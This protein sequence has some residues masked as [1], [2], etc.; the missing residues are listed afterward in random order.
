M[1]VADSRRSVQIAQLPPVEL[2]EIVAAPLEMVRRMSSAI[3]EAT[4]N[5][6]ENMAA[7]SERVASF[8]ELVSPREPEPVIT[9]ALLVYKGWGS[10]V[11]Y[12]CT[13]QKI[14]PYGSDPEWTFCYRKIETKEI[15]IGGDEGPQSPGKD[16]KADVL[17]IFHHQ[18]AEV[19]VVK[20]KKF[21]FSIRT[22]YDE[23]DPMD[24][25][26]ELL[27]LRAKTQDEFEAWVDALSTWSQG[28]NSMSL[29]TF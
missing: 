18:L 22:H 1:S 26:E 20:R 16:E 8:C 7:Q 6:I 28:V 10:W 5:A 9:G 25:P 13:L 4:T 21:E 24:K 23:F 14:A 2:P 11:A 27:K 17:N 19:S 3:V 29:L 15:E 12:G